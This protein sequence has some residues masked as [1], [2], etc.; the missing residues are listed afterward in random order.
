MTEENKQDL[1]IPE[2]PSIKINLRKW[3]GEAEVINLKVETK[4]YN[5]EECFKYYNKIKSDWDKNIK[6]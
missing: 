2:L 4:G 3:L 6:I 1:E 5:L